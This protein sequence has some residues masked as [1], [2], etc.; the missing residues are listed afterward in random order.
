MSTKGRV[1][2]GDPTA[3]ALPFIAATTIALVVALSALARQVAL[4]PS[5]VALLAALFLYARWWVD[6]RVARF[7]ALARELETSPAAA[8]AAIDRAVVAQQNARLFDS[9]FWRI[10]ALDAWRAGAFDRY[11]ALAEAA[12]SSAERTTSLR[13]NAL[14]A[15]AFGRVLRGDVTGCREAIRSWSQLAASDVL[16]LDGSAIVAVASALLLL[17]EGRIDE[18]KSTVTTVLPAIAQAVPEARDVALAIL[19]AQPAPLASS[20]GYRGETRAASALDAAL[21][22]AFPAVKLCPIDASSLEGRAL[23]ALAFEA[24]TPPMQLPTPLRSRVD[25]AAHGM[26]PAALG[27]LSLLCSKLIDGPLVLTDTLAIVAFAMGAIV[28]V[29][30]LLDRRGAANDRASTK[31]TLSKLA[32]S[33][34]GASTTEDAATLEQIA[35][36]STAELAGHACLLRSRIAWSRGDISGALAW[37][38]QCLARLHYAT[39]LRGSVAEHRI[40]AVQTAAVCLAA[41]G[42]SDDAERYAS[43]FASSPRRARALLAAIRWIAAA[44]DDHSD[45][46]RAGDMMGYA[47]LAARFSNIA[48][49]QLLANIALSAGDPTREAACRVTLQR[50][51]HGR[52]WIEAVAPAWVAKVIA[53]VRL[54]LDGPAS[55]DS[56]SDERVECSPPRDESSPQRNQ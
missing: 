9:P 1:S 38:E 41:M 53:P 21:G 5:T 56:A 33:S 24:H 22:R 32:L 50:W 16:D 46:K 52:A 2:L 42:R 37:A 27:V 4:L 44:R 54:A 43:L 8:R 15:L 23:P 25:P 3:R 11:A 30:T 17:H 14:A 13:R 48:E 26:A 31:R 29:L 55:P 12:W 39:E 6:G 19:G 34:D 47:A 40:E 7:E 49:V 35:A 45:A 10:A 51:A 28:L 36:A 20:D 18:A